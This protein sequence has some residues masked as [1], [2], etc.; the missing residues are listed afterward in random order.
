MMTTLEWILI[1]I[2]VVLVLGLFALAS[3]IVK[4]LFGIADAFMR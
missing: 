2:I 3:W 1:G 4:V